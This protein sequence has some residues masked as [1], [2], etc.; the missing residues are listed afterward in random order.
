MRVSAIKQQVK[1]PE[2][3]SI[4]IDGKYSFSLS[5]NDLVAEKLKVGLEIDEPTLAILKKKS[6]D[7]KFKMRSLEWVLSRPHSIREFKDYLKR[8]KAESDFTDKLVEE[9]LKRGYLDD[10]KFAIWWLDRQIRKQKSNRSIEFELRGKGIDRE[11]IVEVMTSESESEVERLK[12]T[13]QKL[14]SR[15]RYQDQQ[16]LTAYLIGKGFSYSLVK[17]VLNEG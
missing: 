1:N 2:R 12:T 4:F 16:K 11:V 5:L 3:A 8:K 13:I 10:K 14:H 7:G 17:E 9:F 6:A 15:T